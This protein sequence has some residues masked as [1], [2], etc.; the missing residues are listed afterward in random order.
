M[1]CFSS[2]SCP[3]GQLCVAARCVNGDASVLKSLPLS[4]AARVEVAA[5]VCG[6]VPGSCPLGSAPSAYRVDFTRAEL[7]VTRCVPTQD[8]GMAGRPTST[9]ALTTDQVEQVRRALLA[10]RT[11]T[12][13]LSALDG[14][15]YALTLTDET[16]ATTQYSP[17]ATCGPRMYEQV[18]TGWNDVW[19]TISS[20]AR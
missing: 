17:G 4:S 8:G 10:V 1:G 7:T 3:T 11:A 12:T 9:Q 13:E 19:T 16:G 6:G 18:V 2:A 20:L 5:F 15:M 14:L